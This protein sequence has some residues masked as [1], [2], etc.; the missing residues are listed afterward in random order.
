NAVADT[1][2]KMPEWGFAGSPLVVDDLVIVATGGRLVAYDI[3]TGEPRW[4]GPAGV[5]GYS[6][7]H[8]ATLGGIKQVLLLKG[9]GVISVAPA[10]GAEL[11][12]Y[13]WRGDGIVQPALTEEGNVLIGSGSGLSGVGVC[14]LAV[15]HGP[16]GWSALERWISPGLKP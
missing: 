6:S 4:L 2:V 3:G 16:D 13:L 9:R 10:T 5:S 15:A 14:C 12:N 11:W 8:L 1:G 7:P